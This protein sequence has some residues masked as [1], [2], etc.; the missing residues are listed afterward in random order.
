MWFSSA[1][2]PKAFRTVSTLQVIPETLSPRQ[3]L[4]FRKQTPCCRLAW[5]FGAPVTSAMDRGDGFWPLEWKGAVY[6]A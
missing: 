5:G 4:G 2:W 3:S 1:D 6:V